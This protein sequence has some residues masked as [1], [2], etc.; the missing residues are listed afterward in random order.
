MQ[1]GLTVHHNVSHNM[2][3]TSTYRSWGSMNTRCKNPSNH[4]YSK[5]GGRG[6]KVCSRWSNS[7]ENFYKDMG[8]RPD[9]TSLDRINNDGNYCKSNCRWSS[10]KE[11]SNNRRSNRLITWQNITLTLKQWT[12]TL[13]V[14][15]SRIAYRLD[16]VWTVEDA[17]F[18]PKSKG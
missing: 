6:I 11:Q 15:L 13:E 5:Y 4:N 10:P 17:L 2:S 18:E 16:H 14:P 8:D 12:E 7:F 1:N 3:Y 9:G